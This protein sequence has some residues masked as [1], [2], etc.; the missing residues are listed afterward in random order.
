MGLAAANRGFP[1]HCDEIVS[2][3]VCRGIFSF[4]RREILYMS[5][6]IVIDESFRSLLARNINWV[7]FF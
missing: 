1:P 7:R 6:Q 3:E 4:G 5:G 2:V